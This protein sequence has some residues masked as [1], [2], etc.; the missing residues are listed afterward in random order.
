MA[1][2]VLMGSVERKNVF[3][4]SPIQV[5]ILGHFAARLCVGPWVHRRGLVQWLSA[6]QACLG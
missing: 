6:G 1:K 4:A 3:P 5:V 2:R